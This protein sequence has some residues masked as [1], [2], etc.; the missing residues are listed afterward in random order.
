MY[1]SKR[2]IANIPD[3]GA[4]THAFFLIAISTDIGIFGGPLLVGVLLLF[5]IGHIG[6]PLVLALALGVGLIP[7]IAHLPMDVKW[8]ADGEDS[9][10][11]DSACDDGNRAPSEPLASATTGLLEE[12]TVEEGPSFWVSIAVQATCLI[13]NVQRRLIRY[14]YESATVV[15]FTEHFGYTEAGSGILVGVLGLTYMLP[16]LGSYWLVVFRWKWDLEGNSYTVALLV[17]ALGIMASVLVVFAANPDQD[18]GIWFMILSA[19]PMYSYTTLASAIGNGHS[20]KFAINDN[21]LFR[22]ESLVAQQE[23]L[24]HPLSTA[25]GL[26]V[27]RNILGD[28]IHIRFLGMLFLVAMLLQLALVSIGWDPRIWMRFV[29]RNSK[30]GMQRP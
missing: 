17:T 3:E 26:T 12:E 15:I 14:A 30:I 10:S 5:H 8:P 20:L 9:A 6:S 16:I 25:I 22:R 2:M 27:G 19:L 4:R 21:R 1:S 23:M 28:A 13:F 24:Q 7:I 29:A 11:D 18:V